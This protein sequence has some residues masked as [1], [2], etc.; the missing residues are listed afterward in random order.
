VAQRFARLVNQALKPEDTTK[1]TTGNLSS[2]LNSESVEVAKA[3][4]MKDPQNTKLATSKENKVLNSV[5][6]KEDDNSSKM[7]KVNT[8]IAQ[9]NSSKDQVQT[10]SSKE[11]PIITRANFT[12]DLVKVVKF[13]NLNDQKELT[14]KIA[15]KELGE[16]TI[17]LTMEEGNLKANISA[18]NKDT[19]NLLS[20]N[21]KE[22]TNSL[23]NNDIR[24]QNVDINIYQ[25]DTTFFN[26]NSNR[27]NGQGQT[28]G[29]GNKTSE[30]F[31]DLKEIQLDI[32]GD[33]NNISALA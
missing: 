22:I 31:A 6:G 23:N 12:E 1:A 26:N 3:D 8:F 14:V 19:F 9:L 15:P 30:E 10:T 16:I 33:E 25:G 24:I 17:K 18:N 28:K 32:N 13:M 20:S 27:G 7:S 29:N 5:M 21:L 4:M 2:T 11:E